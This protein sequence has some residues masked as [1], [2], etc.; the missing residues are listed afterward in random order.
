MLL[1]ASLPLAFA[2]GTTP[3]HQNCGCRSYYPSPREPITF[4]FENCEPLNPQPWKLDLF[5]RLA[6][7]ECQTRLAAARLRRRY[8]PYPVVELRANLKSISHR[9]HL[10]E[11]AFAW[12]LTEETIHLPVGCLQGGAPRAA[13]ASLP[14]AFAKGTTPHHQNFISKY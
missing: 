7:L 3:H 4:A 2:E 8:Y 12:E 14:L 5:F 9:C 1:A 11:V 13:H 10:F 6:K